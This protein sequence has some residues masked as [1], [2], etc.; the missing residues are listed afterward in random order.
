MITVTSIVRLAGDAH[1]YYLDPIST[2]TE[3]GV[4]QLVEKL[5]KGAYVVC[6]DGPTKLIVSISRPHG[7][8]TFEFKGN[9]EEMGALF[10]TAYYFITFRASF[11]EKDDHVMAALS[12]QIEKLRTYA[13][14]LIN[15]RSMPPCIQLNRE[16]PEFLN[17]LGKLAMLFGMGLTEVEDIIAGM[18]L[19][20]EYITTVFINRILYPEASFSEVVD[21]SLNEMKIHVV[22][23][24][25]YDGL[26][27]LGD[28]LE[29][30][31]SS[32]PDYL[33]DFGKGA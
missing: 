13:D 32:R 20:R 33:K 26:T 30:E 21:K 5:A 10:L 16:A 3:G 19:P 22:G 17:E 11:Y 7:I 6:V 28:I 9:C 15:E 24:G 27:P 29:Q 14:V 25:T 12:L 31:L 18:Q 2:N 4:D 23:G 1:I 8:F